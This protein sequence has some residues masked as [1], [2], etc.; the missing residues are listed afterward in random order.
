MHWIASVDLATGKDRTTWYG[1]SVTDC[2]E[3]GIFCVGPRLR[4]A[5]DDGFSGATQRYRIRRK[6]VDVMMVQAYPMSYRRMTLMPSAAFGFGWM[7]SRIA[8]TGRDNAASASDVGFR[9]ELSAMF[10]FRLTASWSVG[11]EIGASYTPTS[12]SLSQVGAASP[13]PGPPTGSLR[14]GIGFQ[15]VL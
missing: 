12:S 15:F 8:A 10:A 11:G 13:L 4:M 9:A 5:R 3:L 2:T 1:S 14:A 7:R 6:S